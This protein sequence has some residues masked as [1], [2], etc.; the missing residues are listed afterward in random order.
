M[1]GVECKISGTT[2]IKDHHFLNQI[3][4]FG[5]LK[6]LSTDFYKSLVKKISHEWFCLEFWWKKVLNQAC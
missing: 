3:G 2:P 6:K 5:F 4:N 1:V